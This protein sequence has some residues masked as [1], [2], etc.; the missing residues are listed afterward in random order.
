MQITTSVFTTCE[1]P[2]AAFV[3]I[4]ARHAAAAL[5]SRIAHA[6][7]RTRRIVARRI[8]L[9]RANASAKATTPAAP[10]APRINGDTATRVQTQCASASSFATAFERW[11]QARH[12]THIKGDHKRDIQF[13]SVQWVQTPTLSDP[14]QA[15]GFTHIAVVHAGAALIHILTGAGV[16]AKAP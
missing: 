1:L 8:Y 15:R 13:A 4:F 14:P 16:E 6:R 5:V 10:Q 12:I 9:P 2:S 3:Y 11:P 7:E